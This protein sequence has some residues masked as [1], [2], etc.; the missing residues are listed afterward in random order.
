MT[1]A[2]KRFKILDTETNIG[3]MPMKSG[4][5]SDLYNVS[6]N[7]LKTSSESLESMIASASQQAVSQSDVLKDALK[8]PTDAISSVLDT[9]TRFAQ[10][11]FGN[12]VD[13]KSMLPAGLEQFGSLLGDGRPEY[14]KILNSV[15]KNCQTRG[16]GYGVPGRRYRPTMDCGAG[17]M[18]G[19]RSGSGVSCNSSTFSNLLNKMSGGKYDNKYK[20]KNSMLQR[21]MSLSG[22]GYNMNMCGVFGTIADGMDIDV[23]SRGAGGLMS[24][25]G[26]AGNTN[27]VLDLFGQT[28]ALGLF[29]K[30]TSPGLMTDFLSN[31]TLPLNVGESGLGNLGT[32][33]F[34]S[35]DGFD[36]S[37]NHNDE[38][39][40]SIG[41]AGKSTD[42]LWSVV[43]N[44]LSNRSF[45]ETMYD[46]APSSD[47]DFT[48]AAFSFI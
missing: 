30:A 13:L 18:G 22:Q 6:E 47:E 8:S 10:G 4:L 7:A 42:D 31:F 41:V 38:G 14:S 29:P 32:R 36:P 33:V 24:I 19:G 40:L 12:L 45:D 39:G 16:L 26:K 27:A 11:G 44:R 25:F 5:S 28:T 20:D 17:R 3:V 9:V 46:V 35:L 21:L 48:L 43:S 23:L 1:V 34:E 15:M 37:W 2:A